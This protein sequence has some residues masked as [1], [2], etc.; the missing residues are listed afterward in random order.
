MRR[1]EALLSAAQGSAPSGRQVEASV[2]APRAV[3]PATYV[4]RRAPAASGQ[5]LSPVARLLEPVTRLRT[6]RAAPRPAPP[7]RS[8]RF[9]PCVARVAGPATRQRAAPGRHRIAR[10]IHSLVARRCAGRALAPATRRKSALGYP[11]PAQPMFSRRASLSAVGLLA[12]V[13]SS[14]LV[15]A[16]PPTAPLTAT[17]PR[18]PRVASRSVPT[19]WRRRSPNAR[20]SERMRA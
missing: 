19:D 18:T 20:A 9:P 17:S 5:T 8:S 7:M 16:P 10:Q 13:T 14:N 2:A 15:R 1:V 12:R 6:V 3:A 11:R 4:Q